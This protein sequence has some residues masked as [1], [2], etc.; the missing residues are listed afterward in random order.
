MSMP[1][2]VIVMLESD[3]RY[4]IDGAQ[5]RAAADATAAGARRAALVSVANMAQK[6][7]RSVRAVITEPDGRVWRL[8]LGADGQL[9]QPVQPTSGTLDD[10]DALQVPGHYRSAVD[11]IVTAIEDG[12][13]DHARH[14]TRRLVQAASAEYGAGHPYALRAMEL[15]AHA[16]YAADS[17]EAACDLYLQAARGWHRRG[18]VQYWSAAQRAY[19]VWH[20]AAF[21]PT[22]AAWQ[23]EELM[24]V[25]RLGGA[26]TAATS[27]AVL[28]HTNDVRR[29][30][31][32]ADVSASGPSCEHHCNAN[33]TS[34][35]HGP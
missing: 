16:S 1:Q 20:R 5:L 30:Q 23:G 18:S 29:K 28:A 19:A 26:Q 10:L 32:S 34:D 24:S 22:L 25:L 11:E 3:G 13:A 33:N 27:R 15:H 31:L 12:R 17:P 6:S 2:V 4:W 14:Q 35:E 7:R 9:A 21:D 8:F